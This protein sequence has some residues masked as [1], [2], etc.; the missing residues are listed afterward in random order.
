MDPAE[1]HEIGIREVARIRSRM[2]D[3]KT[4]AKFEGTLDEFLKFMRDNKEFYVD[5]KDKL[6]HEFKAI[7]YDHIKPKLPSV[8]EKLPTKDVVVEEMPNDG[9]GG[10]YFPPS[11]DGSRPGV[12][13][14]NLNS[15]EKIPLFTMTALCLH[16]AN[17]GHHLQLSR[18][19]EADIPH[20][21]KEYDWLHFHSSP[22][23]FPLYTS[24]IEGWALYTEMLG[25]E[26]GVYRSQYELFG[27]L[28]E[29]I[30]RAARLVVDTGLH[31]FGWSRE[32]A[33]EY[34]VNNTCVSR[35]HIAI[36]VDRY[37]TWPGQACGYKIGELKIK[38]LR[39]KALQ[40]L[41]DQFDLK[42]FHEVI[43]SSGAVSLNMLE[44]R[45]SRWTASVKSMSS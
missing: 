14:A 2:E 19:I 33:I 36:E 25:E 9:P 40:E 20:F 23:H 8:I 32:E 42:A 28:V 31:V 39:E 44:N 16:E 11:V 1:V 24:Y 12:F 30:F 3:I 41:G 5:S 34:F 29:E 15:T 22:F 37:I 4:E 35:E 17:P 43:L 45:V 21:R 38:A 6:L 27:R 26:M 7:I 18:Q 10:M 13:F